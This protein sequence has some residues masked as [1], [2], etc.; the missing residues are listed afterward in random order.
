MLLFTD[1][2]V[3]EFDLEEGLLRVDS[4]S[5][6]DDDLLMRGFCLVRLRVIEVG[7]A[8]DASED[9]GLLRV[10]LKGLGTCV[11]C[12]RILE[13]MMSVTSLGFLFSWR[14]FLF[15]QI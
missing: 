5:T 3:L 12:S 11:L 8:S 2:S 1:L 6:L 13:S 7:D 10:S 4:R 9:M 15:I 14:G